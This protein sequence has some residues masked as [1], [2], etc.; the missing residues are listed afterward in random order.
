MCCLY[1]SL[2]VM[3]ITPVFIVSKWVPLTE[4]VDY[5]PPLY[6]M[7]ITPVFIVSR[8]DPLTECVDYPRPCM[9]CL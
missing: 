5:T 3:F 8:W 9:C 2:Y 1:P 7:F 4:C 6:V